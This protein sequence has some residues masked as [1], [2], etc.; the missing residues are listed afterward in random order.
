MFFP[1]SSNYQKARNIFIQ[2]K[3]E[4]IQRKGSLEARQIRQW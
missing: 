4:I 2:K 1:S 3:I